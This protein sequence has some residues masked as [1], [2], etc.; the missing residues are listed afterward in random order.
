MSKPLDDDLSAIHIRKLERSFER[1]WAKCEDH[2]K[3]RP[4]WVE[5]EDWKD[6]FLL[7][8][9]QGY[10]DGLV[11]AAKTMKVDKLPGT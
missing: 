11:S 1:M 4:P 9:A 10:L 2:K 5:E 3:M 8:Y 7:F 6:L